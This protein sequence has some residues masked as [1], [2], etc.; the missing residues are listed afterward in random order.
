MPVN[1]NR[2]N[3]QPSDLSD[4]LLRRLWADVGRLHRAGIA[5]RSLRTANVMAGDDGRPP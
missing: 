5:H 2:L 1:G 3:P 4:D